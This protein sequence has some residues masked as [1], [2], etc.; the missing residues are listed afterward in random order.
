MFSA[1]DR[2]ALVR[3]KATPVLLASSFVLLG[4]L[5][6]SASVAMSSYLMRS[7]ANVVRVSGMVLGSSS[8]HSSE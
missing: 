2:L 1:F 6:T 3:S 5:V 8:N 7:L 4:G